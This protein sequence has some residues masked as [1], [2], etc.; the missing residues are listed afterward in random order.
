MYVTLTRFHFAKKKCWYRIYLSIKSFRSSAAYKYSTRYLIMTNNLFECNLLTTAA[1]TTSVIKFY[2]KIQLK[3][4]TLQI[5]TLI[6]PSIS[7]LIASVSF[8][9]LESKSWMSSL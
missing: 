4:L 8:L 5:L 6:P 2:T 7:S 9:S 3:L 1:F